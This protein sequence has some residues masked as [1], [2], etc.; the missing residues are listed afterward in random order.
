MAQ[1]RRLLSAVD[2]SQS[3]APDAPT[4]LTKGRAAATCG[5]LILQ[6][7]SVSSTSEQPL[8]SAPVRPSRR[9]TKGP[10]GRRLPGPATGTGADPAPP[11]SPLYLLRVR[12]LWD[13]VKKQPMSFKLVCLYLFMEYV[14]PQQLYEAIAGLPYSKIIIAFATVAF[15]LEGRR[16]RMRVPE[17]MLGI[18]TAILLASSVFALEPDASYAQLSLFFS[19]LFIYLLIANTVDTEERFLVFVFSFLLYSYKMAEFGTR[20]WA[21]AG[22]HFRDWGINGAP[23]WFNNSGEFGIQMCV[24]LPIAIYFTVS[25]RRYWPRWKTL[26]FWSMPTF[27]MISIVGSSSRGALVGLAAAALWM[28]S[29]TRYKFRGIV[30]TIVLAG[31]VYWLL[32]PEQMERLHSM[33]N[34]DTSV[35]RTTMW[36]RGLELMS[37][38]PLLGIGYKNW[39]PYMKRVYGSPLLPHNIFIEAGTEL[40]YSGLIAFVLLIL[41]TLV[42]NYRTRRLTSHL[43]AGNRFIYDMAHGLDA[44]LWGYLAS[45]FFVT[46]LYYPFFWINFA[47]TVALHRAA[48]NKVRPIGATAYSPRVNR[49]RRRLVASASGPITPRRLSAR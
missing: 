8:V 7:R 33:G 40:G 24:F 41:T 31:L 13:F 5:Q 10:N 12:G 42:I 30:A 38:Y 44:A 16:F 27:A 18:F 47:M 28:L 46:V 37:Q 11:A 48:I 35:S 2:R 45:G 1:P 20:S 22:F 34:D 15:F 39:S 4:G 14:R 6:Q 43:P 26:L 32:P 9:V 21:S 19:W 3:Y 36:A 29:K 17:L 25:L 49:G 23:G